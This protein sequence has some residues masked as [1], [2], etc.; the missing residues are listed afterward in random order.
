MSA[1]I[2]R[3]AIIDTDAPRPVFHKIGGYDPDGGDYSQGAIVTACGQPWLHY[4]NSVALH[5]YAVVI[6]RPH[7][8]AFGRPC[9]RCYP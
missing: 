6:R 7:A 4:R 8:E 1:Q 3:V 5:G 9:G 2:E